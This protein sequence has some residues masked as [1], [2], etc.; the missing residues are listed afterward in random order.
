M[1]EEDNKKRLYE[2]KRVKE[3]REKI[4]HENPRKTSSNSNPIKQNENVR[5]GNKVNAKYNK[6]N[7]K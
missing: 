2:W 4:A 6:R 3:K 5:A 1:K 7:T